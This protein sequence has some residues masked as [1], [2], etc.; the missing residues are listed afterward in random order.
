MNSGLVGLRDVDQGCVGR[1]KKKNKCTLDRNKSD[2][3]QTGT[4]TAS[5]FKFTLFQF[6]YFVFIVW[7]RST[8]QCSFH[9]QLHNENAT[10]INK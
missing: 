1:I 5:P 7:F 6:F 9:F 8:M 10:A 3:Y 4:G 2:V